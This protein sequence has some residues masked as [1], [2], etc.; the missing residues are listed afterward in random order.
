MAGELP[1]NKLSTLED[2]N[3]VAAVIAHNLSTED[4]DESELKSK[5]ELQEHIERLS[6]SSRPAISGAEGVAMDK[7]REGIQG[8]ACFDQSN[9]QAFLG[10]RACLERM[11]H[12]FKPMQA[13]V[14]EVRL[15]EGLLSPDCILLG[16][17]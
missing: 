15:A 10:E 4:A 12:L 8:V 3:S 7:L 6:M 11:Q 13:F 9:R 14:T 1:E 5:K 16:S 17:S 2:R